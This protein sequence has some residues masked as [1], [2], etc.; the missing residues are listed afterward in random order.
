MIPDLS[1]VLAERS[2]DLDWL[3]QNRLLPED[4]F[5]QFGKERGLSVWGV[6]KGDPGEFSRRGW[7]RSDR[8]RDDGKLLFHP[9]R[10]Y[11]LLKI[12]HLCELSIT[13]SSYVTVESYPDFLLNA[14][15]HLPSADQI[16][17]TANKADQ[18][19]NFALL[20]EPLY[21][22]R[23]TGRE[24]RRLGMGD[25]DFGLR[26]SRHRE[27]M[28]KLVRDLDP[29]FWMKVHKDLRWDAGMLDRN[30]RLYLLLRLSSWEHRKQLKGAV[31]ASLWIRHI[32]EV[33]RR[34]FEDAHEVQWAEE[35]QEFGDWVAG[36]RREVLGDERPLDHE[37]RSKKFIALDFGLFT[38]SVVRWYVEGETEYWA[39]QHVF[40]H[41]ATSGIELVNLRGN[42]AAGRDNAAL[43]LDE[44]L[45]QDKELRRFSIISFDADVEENVKFVR[46]QVQA[47]HVV[48]Y[49]TAHDP[50]FEFDNFSLEELV[51]IAARLDEEL[52]FDGEAVRQA[53][54]E[55]VETGKQFEKQYRRC[56]ARRPPGLKGAEWGAALARYALENPQ[57]PDN[58]EE[59]VFLNAVL[60]ALQCRHANYTVQQ[61]AYTFDPHTFRLVQ[62]AQEQDN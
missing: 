50:D 40:T 18:I 61:E 58:G 44:W 41:A 2:E 23:I 9:F 6:G 16:A 36:A 52:G 42:I 25:D 51:E 31:S 27:A 26:T 13:P 38:G 4:A 11:P 12:L 55:G 49:I 34:A 22:Q 3:W 30:S 21:W 7:L 5:I 19:I 46:R 24:V 59:R 28:M 1:G 37:L 10:F 15:R 35:D 56:S 14:A 48:G 20:L 17:Q 62:R 32:A 43:K 54:W 39:V 60:A 47:D 57:H 45:R 8:R 53:D 29:E 33:V